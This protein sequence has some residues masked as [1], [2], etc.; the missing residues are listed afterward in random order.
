MLIE[1]LS[2]ARDLSRLREIVGVLARNGVGDLF[3][4]LGFARALRRAGL[5]LRIPRAASLGETPPEV[6]MRR[7]LEELGPT[8]VKLGQLLSGRTDLLP[9]EWTSELAKLR[10]HAAPVA[11]E[12]IR[13]QLTRDL[14]RPPEQV[15]ASLD[16]KPLAA[17][18]IAQVHRARLAD[19]SEVVLKVRRPGIVPRVAADLRL[20]ARLA[21][22]AEKELPEVRRLR[23]RAIARQFESSM[24]AELDLSLEARQLERIA[25]Q[26]VARREIVIPR[27]HRRF[28]TPSLLVQEFLDGPSLDQWIAKGRPG[29]FDPHRIAAVGAATILEMVFVHGLYHAD[30]H[31]GN[32]LVLPDGRLG[33]LDFGMVGRLTDERRREFLELLE[34]V[35]KSRAPEVALVLLDWAGDGEVDEALLNHDVALFLDRHVG[36]RLADIDLSALLADIAVLVRDNGLALPADVAMLLKVFVTLDSLGLALDPDF[37]LAREVEPFVDRLVR[38]ERRPLA[39]LRRGVG[40]IG[41]AVGELPRG[42]RPLLAR[43]R[44]GR[45]HLEIELSRIEDLSHDFQRSVNRLTVGIVTA[46]LIVGTSIALTVPSGSTVL[47]LPAFAFLGFASS[48]VLGVGLLVSIARSG[49]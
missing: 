46:A 11:W 21:E 39:L 47:G 42:L 23:P 27:V 1:T 32:V 41:R 17:A 5:A 34:A 28:T 19:G 12:E 29:H 49:H 6:R 9:P 38:A 13:A 36:A 45:F 14:G 7:A 3:T 37:A 40:E 31:G 48:L 44:H 33:L 20:I 35:V 10:E 15:F 24:R 8:F 2:T 43:L 26:I 25:G 4:R 22:I 16:P 30:P 18:S